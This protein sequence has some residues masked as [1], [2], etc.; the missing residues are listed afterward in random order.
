MLNTHGR[1]D[2]MEQLN[3]NH[4]DEQSDFGSDTTITKLPTSDSQPRRSQQRK[5][6]WM[7]LSMSLLCVFA[8]I[9]TVVVS[10]LM[11][12]PHY[13]DS[14]GSHNATTSGDADDWELGQ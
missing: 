3:L 7:C 14:D 10:E 11:D 6:M 2:E 4:D 8:V 12:G 1:H 9:I 5:W 13:Q